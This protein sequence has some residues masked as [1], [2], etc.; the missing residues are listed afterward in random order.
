MGRLVSTETLIDRVWEDEPPVQARRTLHAYISRIRRVVEGIPSGLGGSSGIERHGGAYLL[1]LDRQLVDLHRF[2]HVA[3]QGLDPDFPLDRRIELFREADG[4]WSGRPLTGLSGVW[5]ARMRESWFQER[6]AATVAWAHAEADAGAPA[7]VLGPLRDLAAENPLVEP[8]TA[9]L[10][11]VH[12]MLG[13]TAEALQQYDSAR[14]RLAD[15]LGVD[16]G[17]ELRSVHQAVLRGQFHLLPP[18]TTPAPPLPVAPD[19]PVPTA[20]PAVVSVTREVAAADAGALA[21][22]TVLAASTG[23]RDAALPSSL[24]PL[25]GRHGER[26][27]LVAA[28]GEH[29]LVSAVG[30]GGIGKTR[31]ALACA[32]ELADRYA[33]G[34][35]YV[36]L[37]P[38]TDGKMVASA[39]AQTLGLGEQLG[40]SAEDTVMAWFGSR[41]A[42][43]VLD[44]CEH[45][46]DGVA[47][48]VERLLTQCPR[49]SVLA[50]SR[51][52]LL[53][54]YERVYTVPGMSVLE[55]AGDAVDLFLTRAAAGGSS[56]TIDLRRV[57]AICRRLDGLALAIELAAARLPTLGLDGLETGL[58]DQ[59]RLLIGGQRAD[60]RHRS[61]RSTLEWSH[62]L[63]TDAQCTVLRRVSIF[64]APFTA[65]DAA[66]LLA[67]WSPIEPAGVVAALAALP[68]HSLMVVVSGPDATRYRVLE[69]IR[70]YGVDRLAETGELS[71]AHGRHL[72][73]C[74]AAADALG[75]SV[76]P[77]SGWRARFDRVVDELRAALGWAVSEPEYHAD[78]YRLAVR[79]AE[80]CFMRGLP[81]EAQRRYEQAAG[82]TADDRQ[83]ASA[84]HSAAEAAKARHAATEALRL[85]R[86][87]ADAALRAGDR[88]QAAYDLAQ[89][90]EIIYRY[91]GAMSEPVPPAEAQQA[92]A[93]ARTLGVDNKAAR[94]RISVAEAYTK[95]ELDPVVTELLD[96][97]LALSREAGDPLGESA[98]LDCLTAVYSARGEIRA[99]AASA[100]RR[101]ELLEGLPMRA[102][103][104]GLELSDAYAMAAETAIAAGDL[105]SARRFAERMQNLPF[106]REE[107][108]LA[109][110]RLL[111]V[112]ALAG[113]WDETLRLS[114][115]FR[116]GWER[117]GR[118]RAGNLSRGAHAVAM[119]QG[120]RG[121]EAGCDVWLRV[122]EE[123]RIGNLMPASAMHYGEVFDALVL[124]HRGCPAAA[125]TLL[126]CPPE[127]FRTWHSGQW[128]A[129]YAAVWAEAAVL[130]GHPDAADRLARARRSTMDNPI[131]LAV[132]ERSAALAAGDRAEV[133]SS[134]QQ[135][136]LA[137]CRYQWARTLIL[138]GGPERTHG[139]D[140]LAAMG[141]TP[142][143]ITASRMVKR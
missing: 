117:A 92:I 119:V 143:T 130:A 8:L 25:I 104:S 91:P 44:N 140:E 114:E 57:A 34:V 134:G 41:E 95:H 30:P 73:W 37:V 67:G 90:A 63:L 98:A 120:M 136:R 133:L 88:A 4:L 107:G 38:V 93:E 40:R 82:L 70:Q 72:R 81:G 96:R 100:V 66:A 125:V 13:H 112:T 46:A 137:G 47:V 49:V 2:R 11:R 15:E 51:T 86:A 102:D 36:D 116:E 138:A 115:R 135:L 54:P 33:D 7:A 14:R 87:A 1:R 128:R 5:V 71:E 61:L 17:P 45:L 35:W 111:V 24:T 85:H 18:T 22:T 118:P 129:W 84:L 65:P 122:A 126:A 80:V 58:A 19:I 108:H 69:T 76:A 78:G 101:P 53:V 77:E 48:L 29:R 56:T 42:L 127:E 12:A 32:A 124:L 109:T 27:A 123:L 131:A 97:A 43:L 59:I 50:T 83:T 55:D 94:A 23:F 10:M 16:P 106:Y 74:L 105:V 6:I 132:V 121:D 139:E 141:A 21:A 113:A 103:T 79:L 99:A 64:A 89:L 9:A 20:L 68:D 3:A 62:K 31:L 60:N 110:G 26:A 142:M 39:V 52:R 28:L 75:A